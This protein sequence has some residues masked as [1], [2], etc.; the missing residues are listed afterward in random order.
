MLVGLFPA[1]G[2]RPYWDSCQV[3]RVPGAHPKHR[4]LPSR[5]RAPLTPLTPLTSS[6]RPHASVIESS[7]VFIIWTGCCMLLSP[8]MQSG[9]K[10]RQWGAVL[11]APASP[12]HRLG[13]VL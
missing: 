3:R 7:W 10:P 5:A 9:R 4:G 8:W 13:W 6:P 2:A 12:L 11:T 1:Y